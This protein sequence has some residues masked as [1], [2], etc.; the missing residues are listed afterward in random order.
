METTGW[1]RSIPVDEIRENP[2]Q[3]RGPV[4][5]EDVRELSSSIQAN[6][7]LQPVIVRPRDDGYELIAGERRWRAARLAGLREIPAIVR[8]ASDRQTAVL[9]L[10]ENLQR[11]DLHFFEEAEGYARLLSEFEL[12]QE[13]LARQVGRSQGA[14]ANKMRL[15]RLPA[16]VRE[17]ISREM[18]TERHARA[19]LAVP[20]EETQCELARSCAREGWTVRELEEHAKRRMTPPARQRRTAVVTD[21]RIFINEFRRAARTL[22]E[23]GFQVEMR[24]SILDDRIRLEVT[25]GLQRGERQT[26]PRA[27]GR[28]KGRPSAP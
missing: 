27:R 8:E 21:A 19:L 9:A 6:G 10:L 24:E 15:L 11:E 26:T 28:Q 7:V 13:E 17:I 4:S 16:S 25:I 5:D 1:L 14:V 2:F 3:P 12:T 18:L 22:R 20:D 23:Q